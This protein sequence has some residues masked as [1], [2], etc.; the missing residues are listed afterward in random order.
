M[1]PVRRKKAA[2]LA[3][4]VALMVPTTKIASPPHARSIEADGR[5]LTLGTDRQFT[6]DAVFGPE[7]AQEVRLAHSLV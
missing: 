3:L 1:H 2:R 7:S 5:S 6:F 4:S